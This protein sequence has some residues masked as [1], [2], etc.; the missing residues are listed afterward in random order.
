MDTTKQWTNKQDD[1]K[2]VF[3]NL[4]AAL[5]RLKDTASGDDPAVTHWTLVTKTEGL[6]RTQ[7]Q[8]YLT[9]LWSGVRGLSSHSKQKLCICAP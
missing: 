8:S 4:A 1:M 5:E 3:Q 6:C 9:E 2:E 7:L